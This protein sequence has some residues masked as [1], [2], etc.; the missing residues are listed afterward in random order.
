[1]VDDKV[2]FWKVV[3]WFSFVCV[4]VFYD[5]FYGLV[6]LLEEVCFVVFCFSMVGFGICYF[7]FEFYGFLVVVMGGFSGW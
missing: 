1:M 4:L 6:Y 2:I 7:F 5:V 3:L